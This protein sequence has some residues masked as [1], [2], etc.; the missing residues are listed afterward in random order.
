M[1]RN[2]WDKVVAEEFGQGRSVKEAERNAAERMIQSIGDQLE[3]GLPLLVRLPVARI[4]IDSGFSVVI[5]F[6]L[7]LTIVAGLAC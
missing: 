7:T 1:V 4:H 3:S 5:L 2:M 6:L